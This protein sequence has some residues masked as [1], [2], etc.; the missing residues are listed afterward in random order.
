MNPEQTLPV[1]QVA[2]AVAAASMAA[3]T[4]T[5]MNGVGAADTQQDVGRQGAIESCRDPQLRAFEAYL[6]S[7]M[8]AS[9]VISDEDGVYLFN[10]NQVAYLVEGSRSQDEKKSTRRRVTENLQSFS[11]VMTRPPTPGSGVFT[12]VMTLLFKFGGKSI[13]DH[14]GLP[15]SGVVK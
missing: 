10:V 11:H 13:F 5:V 9:D 1:V 6:L 3:A 14:P 4:A 2:A 15:P 12:Y 8:R 7:R